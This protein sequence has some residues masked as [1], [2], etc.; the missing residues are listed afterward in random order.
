M[1]KR[2]HFKSSVRLFKKHLARFLTIMAVALVAVSFTSGLSEVEEKLDEAVIYEYEQNSVSDL[3]LKSKTGDFTADNLDYL[4]EQYGEENVFLTFCYEFRNGGKIYRL[5]A[6]DLT[7]NDINTITYLG[8]SAPHN[9]DEVLMERSTYGLS[10]YAVGEEIKL[11]L[12]GVNKTLTVSGVVRHPHFL[13]E[14]E[15][16]SYQFDGA[17]V[18]YVMYVD[19][20]ALSSL[21]GFEFTMVNDVYVKLDDATRDT[22]KA[23]SGK[24][25]RAIEQEK[26]DITDEIGEDNV[27]VL[28]LYENMGLYSLVSYGSKIGLISIVFVAFFLAVTLLVVYSSMSRLYAEERQEIACQKTLGYGDIDILG[29]YLAFDIVAT[30]VGGAIAYGVGLILTKL[31]YN[32]FNLQYDMPVYPSGGASYYL[33]YFAIVIVGT[34]LMTLLTGLRTVR[35]KPVALLTPKAPKAGRKVI[36]ERIP[37][38]WNH[39]SFKHKSTVRNVLLFRSRFYMT[40][41]SVVGSTVLVFAGLGLMDN[42]SSIP[43]GQT[44]ISISILL[45]VFSAM[46]CAL[47]IYNLTNINVSERCR[48]IATLMVLGYSDEEVLGYVYR[49]IYLMCALGALLGLPFGVAFVHFVFSWIGFGDIYHIQWWSYLITPVVTMLFCFLSTRLLKWKVIKTDMNASLKTL[50]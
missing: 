25:K 29:K 47:V 46:L 48:E 18:D 43:D 30:A 3:Y 41:I 37:L 36:V 7:R 31:I 12:F 6:Q 22:F 50:E 13:Y 17:N 10:S 19:Y 9:D 26:K 2:A 8:G 11:S 28:S 32:A 49:E 4:Y 21:A 42:S 15:N 16:V 33:G 14:R 44:L 24:Y 5:Y 35:Q 27:Q 39:L 1:V 34:A 38:I 40:V 23:Y 20:S 45:V